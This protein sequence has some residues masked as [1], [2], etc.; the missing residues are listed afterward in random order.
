VTRTASALALG[1]LAVDDVSKTGHC[2][3]VKVGDGGVLVG[4]G[5]L[6]KESRGRAWAKNKVA[7][8][9]ARGGEIEWCFSTGRTCEGLGLRRT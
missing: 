5:T 7:G 4:G 3:G 2:A 1:L 6:E 8:A 9:R